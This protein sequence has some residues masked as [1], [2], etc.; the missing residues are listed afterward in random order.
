M[1]RATS[2]PAPA[3][4]APS[5][6]RRAIFGWLAFVVL[7]F[8]LGGAVGTE[9]LADEDTGNGVVA[10]SPTR[11][12]PTPTSRDEADEQV[13]VQG[14]RR[15]QG[16]R[17]RVHG[18]RRATSSRASRR[19]HGRRRGRVPARQGQRG[20]ALQGR[21][22]RA[23]HLQAPGRRRRRRR[24][25]STP[26]SPPPPP[27]RRRIPSCGSSSSATRAPTRRSRSRFD[28]DFKKAEFL[29]LPITLLILIVAFGALVA[30]GRPAAAR[31][32]P[33]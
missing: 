12:S 9:E 28:D 17:R 11:R 32:S 14:T 10:A 20:P 24:T 2:P 23:R 26:R 21:P 4:G 3:A 19:T 8:V 25:A 18:R 15:G 33:P 13:L 30:A 29:S 22:L 27:P 6:A 7:A 31:R 5:T 16:R 1:P